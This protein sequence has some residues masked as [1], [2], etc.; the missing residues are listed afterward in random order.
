MGCSGQRW[1]REEE[2]MGPGGWEME[3]TLACPLT[4]AVLVW[5]Y[6][7]GDLVPIHPC[8]ALNKEAWVR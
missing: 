1:C 2:N 3:L 7:F 8:C 5:G 6:N 4:G